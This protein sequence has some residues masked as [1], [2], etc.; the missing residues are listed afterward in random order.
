MG[1]ITFYC[2]W[3]RGRLVVD[4]RGAEM[5]VQCPLC[6]KNITVPQKPVWL[7][8]TNEAL[9]RIVQDVVHGRI[10]RTTARCSLRDA[11]IA[12]GYNPETAHVEPDS[13]VDLLSEDRLNA[14]IDNNVASMHGFAGYVQANDPDALDG[15][16]AQELV[17]F[18]SRVHPR[19]D[20]SYP[21]NS[22]GSIDWEERWQQAAKDSGDDDALRVFEATGRM[23]ALVTSPIWQS[24]GALWDD[25][26]G[27]AFAP[28]AFNSGMDL[29]G[30]SREDAIDV[31]LI[32]EN[33]F[34]TPA[35]IGLSSR[36]ASFDSL[37]SYYVAS[38][39]FIPIEDERV[40]EYLWNQLQLC[41]H[42]EKL[43]PIKVLHTC[44][45]CLEPICAACAAQGCSASEP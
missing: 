32:N 14:V 2:V 38:R 1:D 10:N 28:F 34:S 25:S 21:E 33:Y 43:K 45:D 29:I 22:P 40:M 26:M 4:D 36:G 31:G 44:V 3:C 16:P 37:V 27:N 15:R 17:R 39:F 8:A 30:V 13:P 23:I 35:E 6:R 41:G 19:G 18:G 12:A 24:L 11:I 9:R 7:P 5:E 20:P 42:C